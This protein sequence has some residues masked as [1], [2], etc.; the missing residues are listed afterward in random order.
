LAT[1]DAN[2]DPVISL[3]PMNLARNAPFQRLVLILSMT[4]VLTL[5]SPL[6][7]LA[8]APVAKNDAVPQALLVH[9]L[10]MALIR[11]ELKDFLINHWPLNL[12]A[13]LVILVGR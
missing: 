7:V 3:L 5:S 9:S 11:M 2:Q 12:V 10:Q 13:T 4:L 6:P 1:P 8:Q